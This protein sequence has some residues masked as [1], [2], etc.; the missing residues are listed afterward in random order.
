MKTLKSLLTNRI[1]SVWSSH[2][3]QI[4]FPGRQTQ[5]WRSASEPPSDSP[6]DDSEAGVIFQSCPELRRAFTLPCTSVIGLRLPQ[7]EVLP[8]VK[9]L[10]SA[11]AIPVGDWQSVAFCQWHPHWWNNSFSSEGG[12]ECAPQHPP[13]HAI[14]INTNPYCNPTK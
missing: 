6:M 2:I 1:W 11:K 8:S 7:E 4:G 9:Q 5:R 10:S 12:S 14:S 3:S 13:Q